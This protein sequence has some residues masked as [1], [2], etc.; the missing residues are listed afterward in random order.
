VHLPSN[1]EQFVDFEN[2]KLIQNLTKL[3]IE[4]KLYEHV[5]ISTSELTNIYEKAFDNLMR[6]APSLTILH[7]TGGHFFFPNNGVS[8]FVYKVNILFLDSSGNEI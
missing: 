7:P 6:M 1:I 3:D 8:I 5:E 2:V 4:F